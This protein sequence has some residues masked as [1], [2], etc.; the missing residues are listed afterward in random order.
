[1]APGTLRFIPLGGL[2]EIGMNCMVIECEGRAVVLDCGVTFPSK[3]PGV[4]IIHPDFGYIETIRDRLDA[5][6]ITHAHEDHIG[7]LP[8]LLPLIPRVPVYGPPYALRH[9]ARRLEEHG[10]KADLR[11]TRAGQSF[12]VGPFE[13]EPL[14]VNHSIPDATG[15]ILR[16]PAGV[17][18][19]SGD[20]KIERDPVDNLAFD[21]ERLR[22]A[23]DAG[24]RL[25][26]SDSTNVD[27]EGRA[28]EEREVVNA[29]DEIVRDAKQR[30]C[31]AVFASNVHRL[32]AVI[33]AAKKHRRKICLLGRSLDNHAAISRELG[34]IPPADAL[35]VSAEMA[36]SVPRS[37]LVV[38]ATGTQGEAAAALGRIA[39]GDH[40]HLTL[41]AGDQ[42][43]LSSRV[44]PGHEQ[45]VFDLINSLERQGVIV[46]HRRSHKGV[47]VSGHACREEQ[48]ELL[49]LVRPRAFLPVHGTRYHLRLHAELA[50]AAG[51]QE[52]LVVENGSIAELDAEGFRE[53]GH[54]RSGRVYRERGRAVDPAVL[55]DRELMASL[56]LVLASL[57]VGDDGELLGPPKVVSRGLYAHG[58]KAGD[59]MMLRAARFVDDEIE[60]YDAVGIEA[61]EDQ[62]RRSLKRFFNRELGKKPLVMATAVAVELE[63]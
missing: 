28:G 22:R 33:R 10:Q 19:H 5:V 26:L 24:V 37:E 50:Q 31:V 38:V 35:F 17:V 40:R 13:V 34:F 4:D 23:G 8:F 58:D 36:R 16:T 15:L 9:I 32:N 1:M 62:A 12:G 49:D 27:V 44:I 63:A 55:S 6:L 52:T 61:L 60:R 48:R 11:P 47:H 57:P 18:V 2:G 39:R 46:H 53:A 30:V 29:L 20:F 56:G 43:V 21:A 41:E 59:A 54:V 14:R 25:L 45:S 3:E 7:A 51:V 42:V